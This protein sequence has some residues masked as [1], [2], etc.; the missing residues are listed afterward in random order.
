M[1]IINI[2]ETYYRRIVYYWIN[3]SLYTYEYPPIGDYR[4]FYLNSTGGSIW[5]DEVEM[6]DLSRYQKKLTR[7]TIKK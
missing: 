4:D 3:G 2:P 1:K 7:K 5:Y 6:Y